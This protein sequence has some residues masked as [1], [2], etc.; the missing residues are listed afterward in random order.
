[1]LRLPGGY[2][3]ID[4]CSLRVLVVIALLLLAAIGVSC[5]LHGTYIGYGWAA[6]DGRLPTKAAD[7]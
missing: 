7:R 3:L 1:M 5:W 6:A 2:I 4:P